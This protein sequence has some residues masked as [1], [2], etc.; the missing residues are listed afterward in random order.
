[1]PP[2]FYAGPPGPQTKCRR[3]MLA[4][5]KAESGVQHD[6]RLILAR[7]LFAPARFD[8]QGIVNLMGLKWRFHNFDQLHGVLWKV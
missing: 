7:Q 5:A 2:F 1:M 6:N 4:G 8:K 3:R